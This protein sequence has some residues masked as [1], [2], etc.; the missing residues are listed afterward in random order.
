MKNQLFL[1]VYLRAGLFYSMSCYSW[2]KQQSL[3]YLLVACDALQL[4]TTSHI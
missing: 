3:C 2:S 4:S 1:M